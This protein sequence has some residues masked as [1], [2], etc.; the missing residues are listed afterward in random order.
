V[1][2]C[3]RCR[4]VSRISNSAGSCTRETTHALAA[5]HNGMQWVGETA[6][7]FSTTLQ[8]FRLRMADLTDC[9]VV[10]AAA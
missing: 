4:P 10:E 5:R 6:K 1:P 2:S 3:S 9:P 8:V 7:Y